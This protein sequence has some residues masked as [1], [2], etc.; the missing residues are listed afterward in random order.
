MYPIYAELAEGTT[1]S[2]KGGFVA[3]MVPIK[4]DSLENQPLS[5][6]YSVWKVDTP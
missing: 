3:E 4:A 1:K 2:D 6:F 5:K